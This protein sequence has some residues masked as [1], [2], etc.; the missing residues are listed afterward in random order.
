MNNGYIFEWNPSVNYITLIIISLLLFLFSRGT[1]RSEPLGRNHAQVSDNT[2]INKM[3]PNGIIAMQWAFS[4]KKQQISFEYVEKEDGVKLIKSV[5]NSEMLIKKTDKNDYLE[6]NK[7]HVVFALMES[8]GFNFLEYDNINN[9]D[10]LGKLRPYFHQGFVF[11]RF[12]AE[13][14]GTASTVSNLFFNSPI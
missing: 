1:L 10:L 4:D 3:V 8:F 7:P 5:F 12:L 6:N 11:K 14:V 13:Y 2:I 9:N